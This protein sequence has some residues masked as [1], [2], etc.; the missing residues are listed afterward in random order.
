[1]GAID[2]Y[3]DLERQ[4]ESKDEEITNLESMDIIKDYKRLGR[5]KSTLLD[6]MKKLYPDVKFEEYDL[7][8]DNGHLVALVKGFNNNR[9]RAHYQHNR[10]CVKC[11]LTTLVKD[12]PRLG[13][14]KEQRLMYDYFSKRHFLSKTEEQLLPG[15]SIANIQCDPD[16][17]LAIYKEIVKLH[18]NI[19]DESAAN[20]FNKTLD[21]INNMENEKD[22]KDA[23]KRLGLDFK[24]IRW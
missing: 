5:E 9:E 10:L 20:L 12:Y 8:G 1:M 22:K 13:L 3:K 19:D 7:C 17:A 15:L 18:P 11:G 16:L 23:A 2:K 4:I 6:K 24:S 21:E 14:S